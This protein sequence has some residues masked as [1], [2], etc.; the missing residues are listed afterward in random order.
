MTSPVEKLHHVVELASSGI[1]DRV[2][3]VQRNETPMDLLSREY[4][5]ILFLILEARAEA[6]AL[7]KLWPAPFSRRV[8]N[9]NC[10][11]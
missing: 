3:R 7:L 1:R 6:L 8:Y 10:N 11:R 2:L 5:E 9:P 4:A